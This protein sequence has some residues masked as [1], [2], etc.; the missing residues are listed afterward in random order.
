MNNDGITFGAHTV[1]HTILTNIPL[2]QAKQE[3]AQ[4]KMDIENILGKEVNTF[5]YPNGDS[6]PELIKLVEEIGFSCAVCIH[7]LK[8]LNLNDNPI[9]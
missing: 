2:E 7:P 4:S 5:S 6:N 3:I 8:L 9:I 1:N